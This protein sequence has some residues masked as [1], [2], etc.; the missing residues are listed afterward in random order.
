MGERLDT[1]ARS[2]V[3]R[4]RR[5]PEASEGSPEPL[6]G[7]AR[8]HEQAGGELAPHAPE[9]VALR[10]RTEIQELSDLYGI[11]VPRALLVGLTPTE[12]A[13]AVSLIKCAVL[14]VA[15][16]DIVI[17]YCNRHFGV[18]ISGFDLDA[19]RSRKAWARIAL[20]I[21]DQLGSQA[22][23]YKAA[24]QV[25]ALKR[26]AEAL[27]D[28]EISEKTLLALVKE[29]SPKPTSSENPRL[30]EVMKQTLKMQG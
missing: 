22:A 1:K 9:G 12:T 30:V 28:G 17:E 18:K 13:A 25:K 6:R 20:D 5:A 27:D 10:A 29:P 11:E 15:N 23:F 26:L 21:A 24:C 7:G 14:G 4:A 16:D 8:D 2:E 3:R 19:V